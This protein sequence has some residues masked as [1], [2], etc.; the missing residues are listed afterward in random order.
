MA[1]QVLFPVLATRELIALQEMIIEKLVTAPE[2]T[3]LNQ[4]YGGINYAKKI[5]IVGDLGLAM[6]AE[7]GCS[8]TATAHSVPVD[9]TKSWAPTGWQIEHDECWADYVTTLGALEMTPGPNKYD[10]TNTDIMKAL[11]LRMEYALR[12]GY[13]IHTWFGDTDAAVWDDSPAGVLA[14]G[15]DPKYFNLIDGFWKQLFAIGAGT[16]SQKVAIA[17]NAQATYALQDSTLTPTLAWGY[18][19]DL[20]YGKHLSLEDASDLQ[21]TCTSSLWNKAAKYISDKSIPDTYVNLTKGIGQLTI[22]NTPVIKVAM[23][24]AIIREYEN[25]GTKYNAPHRAVLYNK[26]NLGIAVPGTAPIETIKIIPTEKTEI[27]TLRAKDA[28]DAKVIEDTK[29]MVAF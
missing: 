20:I 6:Q 22:N 9:V 21:I 13:I 1:K 14:T 4:F 15:T 24:D 3:L 23:F 17:A 7:Q 10:I 18:L 16:A 28:F 12:K 5:G 2:L 27:I 25:N 26:A 19:E 11:L 8:P 29:V